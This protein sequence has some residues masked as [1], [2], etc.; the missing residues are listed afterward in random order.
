ML[1]LTLLFYEFWNNMLSEKTAHKKRLRSKVVAPKRIFFP[2]R[3][4]CLIAGNSFFRVQCFFISR[5]YLWP[6]IPQRIW[7][8]LKEHLQPWIWYMKCI[9]QIFLFQ[10]YCN[11]KG[12]LTA[13]YLSGAVIISGGHLEWSKGNCVSLK[14][15]LAAIPLFKGIKLIQF[16]QRLFFYY[17]R[18]IVITHSFKFTVFLQNRNCSKEIS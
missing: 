7:Y 4:L 6:S 18:A 1:G 16:N 9:W 8:F 15:A 12:A 17:K 5:K 14:Q 11:F 13:I 3:F 10:T 2:R